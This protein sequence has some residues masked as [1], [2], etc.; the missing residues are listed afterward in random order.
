MRPARTPARPHPAPL[1]T[2]LLLPALLAACAPPAAPTRTTTQTTTQSPSAPN[3]HAQATGTWV[4]GTYSSAYGARF[5]RLWVPAGYAGT[6]RPLMVMLH[7][8]LQDG[9]DFAAGTRMNTLADTR[10]FLV[11]YPEQGTLYNSADCWNWY[12]PGNQYRGA[13]EPAVIAGMIGW[14]KGT[15]AVDSARVAV[16]G[17]SA[18]AAMANIMGCTYPDLIRG[19]AS[20]AGVMY[21]GA[22]TAAGGVNAMSYGSIYDPNGR[23][24]ACAA[25]MG[26]SRHAMPTLVFQGSADPTVNPVNATQTLTQWAQA[27]DLA[28]GTD[29]ND[30]DDTPDATV[31]GAACRA[32]TRFDYRTAGGTTRLQRYSVTGMGHA[33]PGGSSA[34]TYTDPCAP[35]ASTLILNFF[36]F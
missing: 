26:K 16:A 6:P 22:T 17:L 28:D 24:A 20:V 18:G 19:V 7:G 23:G 11:L 14:V 10:G 4:S 5:Y 36:G 31:S 8:C 1:L 9:Y 34:G 15:Y 12:L 13:G 3:L 32:Y 25:E 30:P 35:D 29:N 33:W 27:N 21:Q 2:G